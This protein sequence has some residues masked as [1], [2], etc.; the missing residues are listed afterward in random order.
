M[1]GTQSIAWMGVLIGIATL[2]VS[3]GSGDEDTVATGPVSVTWWVPNW[4]ETAARELA[5]AFE[6]EHE[7]ITVELVI[8]TW[9]G[10][11]NQ[12]RAGLMSSVPPQLIT[13]LESRISAYAR[14][15]LLTALDDYYASGIGTDDFI[16][17]ALEINSYGGQIYGLPFRHDGSG[18]IYNRT[19]FAEAGYDSFPA[20]WDEAMAASEALTVDRNGD[21]AVDQYAMAWPL[22]NQTNAVTRYL[23][24]LFTFGGDILN[25]DLTASA[26][27]SPAGV[28]AM[29]AIAGTILTRNIAPRSTMELDNTLLRDLFINESIAWYICGQFDIGPIREENPD[30]D[31]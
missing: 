30:I 6:A 8:T 29:D 13:E 28:Q 22:G 26:L 11:E 18:V 10:M 24:Q 12:I 7:D 25:D 20:T 31:L 5:T 21:G 4:D 23:Q 1:K 27:D 17:S 2:F 3:C 15:G 16:Q 14:S 9:D 19:L